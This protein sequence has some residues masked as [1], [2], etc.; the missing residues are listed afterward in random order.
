MHALIA[1][2]IFMVVYFFIIS[3]KINRVIPAI[4]GA[5]LLLFFGVFKNPAD[6]FTKYIDFNTIFLLIGMMAFVFTIQETGFFEYVAFKILKISKGSLKKTFL[7]LNFAVFTFSAFLD[8]VTTILIFVPITL[9]IADAVE[10][11]PSF[12]IIAEIISSNIG[13]TTTLIGDPPNIMIG[14]AAKL[15][16]LNFVMNTGVA[17]II[18]FTVSIFVI[19]LLNFK[20]LNVKFES[21]TFQNAERFNEKKV[22]KSFL[23]VILTILLFSIQEFIKVENSIIALGMG[24]LAILIVGDKEPGDYLGKIEWETIFF[25]IGLFIV[26]GALEDT[27]VLEKF[28]EYLE[29]AFGGSERMFGLSLFSTSFV[30][31]GFVDNIPFTATMIP[32]IKSLPRVNPE[33]FVNLKPIWWALS[34]GA[35]LGGNLTPIGASANVVALAILEKSQRK[36]MG[37]W[38]FLK[39][40]LLINILVFVIALIFLDIRYF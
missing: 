19:Y 8:N 7:L 24:F 15:S 6:V 32:I 2:L 40:T 17:G 31:S 1:I 11:E 22:R 28:A 4:L 16:F 5:V 38:R 29:K 34:L 14:S 26:T 3:E 18:I 27:G 25:F 21:S 13:G 33:I 9:A 30:M 37:F 35:C 39:N 20:S 36:K 12:M 23:L 10:I